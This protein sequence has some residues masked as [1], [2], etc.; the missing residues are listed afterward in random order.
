MNYERDSRSENG[1]MQLSNQSHRRHV[2][3]LDALLTYSCA[4]A[5]TYLFTYLRSWLVEYKTGNMSET[6]EDGAK[7]TIDH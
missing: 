7:V 3:W 4:E 1:E 2:Q 6:V 5:L